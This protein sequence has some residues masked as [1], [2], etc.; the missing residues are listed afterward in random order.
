MA[1]RVTVAG[2]ALRRLE[3]LAVYADKRVSSQQACPGSGAPGKHNE[4]TWT[5]VEPMF[6]DDARPVSMLVLAQL[7]HLKSAQRLLPWA[8]REAR[9]G[10]TVSH[11]GHAEVFVPYEAGG[12]VRYRRSA[13]GTARKQGAS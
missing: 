3:G 7:V 8:V 1:G 10:K 6:L 2:R 11:R 4:D 12:R 5:K 13:G 9:D